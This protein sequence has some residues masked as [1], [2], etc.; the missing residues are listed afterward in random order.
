MDWKPVP[1]GYSSEVNLI[2]QLKSFPN[3]I[4]WVAGHRHLNNVTAFPSADPAHP[5]NSFWE[6]ETKSLREFPE[7][8]RTFDIVR[9]SD[10]TV[11]II[12]TDVDADMEDGSLA[13][14]GRTYA[15]ASNQIYGLFGQPL[16]TGSVSYNAELVKQLTPGMKEKL[17]NY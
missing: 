17:K 11:S 4:L 12:T 14:I 9:N 10:N 13:A 7:Q 15:I 8:F 1:P 5:E 16:E 2:E 6:V 3:L